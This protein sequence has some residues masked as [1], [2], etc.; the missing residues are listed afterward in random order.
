MFLAIMASCIDSMPFSRTFHVMST[1]LFTSFNAV[2]SHV[3]FN[4]V[5]VRVRGF[6]SGVI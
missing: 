2:S 4:A 3:S 6:V 1:H 5:L